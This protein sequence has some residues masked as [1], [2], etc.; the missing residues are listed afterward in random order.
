[1]PWQCCR[2]EQNGVSRGQY[3][4]EE[5]RAVAPQLV[6]ARLVGVCESELQKTSVR[7]VSSSVNC[8][9]QGYGGDGAGSG[10]ASSLQARCNPERRAVR[11]MSNRV[12]TACLVRGKEFSRRDESKIEAE[13]TGS[14]TASQGCSML[15]LVV[16][17]SGLLQ[18][19]GP[20]QR[21]IRSSSLF[22]QHPL[23]SHAPTP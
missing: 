15:S 11:R 2:I 7:P 18:D 12:S 21:R 6:I 22:L 1:V 19:H 23:L 10:G 5:Q 20:R 17:R 8:T 13:R 16:R 4:G 14:I 3:A 9:V